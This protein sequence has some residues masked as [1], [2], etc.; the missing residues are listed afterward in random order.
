ME[1]KLQGKTAI[2]AG[3]ASNIGRQITLSLAAEGVKVMLVD[4]DGEQADKVAA[5]ARERGGTVHA[6]RCDCTDRAAVEATAALA[7]QQLGHVDILVNC[8]GWAEHLPFL[9]K[10]WSGTDR[11]VQINFW[12]AI[13]MTRAVL[14]AMVERNAGRVI[15]VNSD[16]GKNG[17]NREV[18][19]S[20]AKAG[21]QGFVRALCKEVGRH[22]ITVNGVCPSMTVPESDAD[23]GERSMHYRRERPA[24]LMDRIV[25]LYPMRRVGKPSDVAN[26]VVFLASDAASFITGQNISVNGG[27]LTQ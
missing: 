10:D 19:Y 2:V 20:A 14:P 21:I 16:A 5:L 24:E 8:I 1:L 11:E 6:T 3:G 7:L 9:Q 4:L 17:E 26:L 22:A 15:C 27:F 13:N 12:T 23:V 25:K 18:I